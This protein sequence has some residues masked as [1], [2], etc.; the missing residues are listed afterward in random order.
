M[1]IRKYYAHFWDVEA[2]DIY[3]LEMSKKNKKSV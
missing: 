3:T 1:A 2:I